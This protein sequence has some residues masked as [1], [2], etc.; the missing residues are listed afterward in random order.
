VEGIYDEDQNVDEDEVADVVVENLEEWA[1]NVP[2]DEQAMV[3]KNEERIEED[4]EDEAGEEPEHKIENERAQ[5]ESE[6][7]ERDEPKEPEPEEG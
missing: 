4:Q 6:S 5:E 3:H 1:A 7:E 2:E